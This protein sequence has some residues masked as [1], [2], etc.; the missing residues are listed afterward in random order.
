M[1]PLQLQGDKNRNLRAHA[2][3]NL[4]TLLFKQRFF[5]LCEEYDMT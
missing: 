3:Q 2:F 5:V 4:Q 1:L